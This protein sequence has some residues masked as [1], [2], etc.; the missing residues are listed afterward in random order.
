M[1]KENVE[2]LENKKSLEY[3][4]KFF[5]NPLIQGYSYQA[6]CSKVSEVISQG[7]LNGQSFLSK[8]QSLYIP[9]LLG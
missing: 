9:S 3:L 8:V 6:G 1:N 4:E 5:V 7:P 2:G